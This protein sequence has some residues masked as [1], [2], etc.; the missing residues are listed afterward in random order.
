[1]FL[2]AF[3]STEEEIKGSQ[4]E[5]FVL[6]PA[7]G[8]LPGIAGGSRNGSGSRSSCTRGAVI[9]IHF[10]SAKD[11]ENCCCTAAA[12][13]LL[14]QCSKRSGLRGFLRSVFVSAFAAIS[15][16]IVPSLFTST[17]SVS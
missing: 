13:C 1:M 6:S 8:T 7:A 10:A 12:I 9:R 15:I 11:T 17:A 16:C 2:Q 14:V 3:L 5:A 4:E